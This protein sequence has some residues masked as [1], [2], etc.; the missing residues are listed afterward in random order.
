RAL[1]AGRERADALTVLA[2]VFASGG[3]AVLVTGSDADA[4]DVADVATTERTT[5]TL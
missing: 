3:S 4:P 1:I 2:R 5:L